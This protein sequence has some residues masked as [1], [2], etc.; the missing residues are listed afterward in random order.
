MKYII[1]KN[2]VEF[3]NFIM[4][5]RVSNDSKLIIIIEINGSNV[6]SLVAIVPL[7][8]YEIFNTKCKIIYDPSRIHALISIRQYYTDIIIDANIMSL[9]LY[10]F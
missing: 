2:T 10:Y 9:L 7:F 3:L 1:L 4:F 8:T 6:T 5:E